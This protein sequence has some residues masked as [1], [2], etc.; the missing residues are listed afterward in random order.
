MKS[1]GLWSSLKKE[2][3]DFASSENVPLLSGQEEKKDD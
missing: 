1:M 2:P 3:E